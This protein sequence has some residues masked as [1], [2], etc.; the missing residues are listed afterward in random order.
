MEYDP[1][2]VSFA[3][4]LKVWQEMHNPCAGWRSDPDSQY[5]SAIYTTTAEQEKVTN[6]WRAKMEASG[7]RVSTEVKPADAFWMAEEYH[8]RYYEKNRMAACPRNA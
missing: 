6:N 4:L 7:K 3:A 5:R 1:S 2:V 8:Q